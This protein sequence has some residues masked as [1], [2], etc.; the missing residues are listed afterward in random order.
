MLFHRHD[1]TLGSQDSFVIAGTLRQ[2]G[3]RWTLATERFLP[4]PNSGGPLAVARTI[5]RMNSTAKGYLQRRDLARPEIQW[6][7]IKELWRR[8]EATG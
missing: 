3:S 8:V 1:D 6:A 4:G 5:R 7:A 2:R